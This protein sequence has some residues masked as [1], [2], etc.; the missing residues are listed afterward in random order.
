MTT[1]ALT[2]PSPVDPDLAEIPDRVL[3]R[4]FLAVYGVELSRL[5]SQTKVRVI[6]VILLAAPWIAVNLIVH[7]SRLPLETLY[8][9]YLTTTGLATPMFVLVT[10]VQ[11]IFPLVAAFVS[12]DIFSA[13]DGHGTYKT[14]L[15][16]S[17][18]RRAV[19]WGKVGAGWTFTTGIVVAMALSSL[20]AGLVVVGHQPFIT[21]GADTVT[22]GRGIG[23]V[24]LA[25]ASVIPAVLAFASMAMLVSVATRSSVLG[26]VVPVVVGLL[27]QMYSFLNAWDTVRHLLLSWAM[28]G[29]RGILDSPARPM[30]LERGLL[31]SLV[32]IVVLIVPAY[33]VFRRRDMTGG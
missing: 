2:G 26:V 22:A 28:N 4:G 24:L 14:I 7:Q 1:Q 3:P 12:G 10:A 6:A 23:L 17:V 5:L 19:F 33:V 25:W 13:D 30:E 21:V 32:Y 9:R 15:T 8:G 20:A 16:R 29:W 11:W 27:F 31:I 18:S